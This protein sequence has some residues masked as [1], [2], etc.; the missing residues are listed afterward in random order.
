MQA[1]ILILREDLKKQ[2][3]FKPASSNIYTDTLL[4]LFKTGINMTFLLN[5]RYQA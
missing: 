1:L 2:N 4:T 3:M 5:H